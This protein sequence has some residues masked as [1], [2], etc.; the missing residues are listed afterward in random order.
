M[1][2]GATGFAETRTVHRAG[3][4][5]GTGIDG[6]DEKSPRPAPFRH[7]ADPPHPTGQG[8]A[9]NFR[10]A[11]KIQGPALPVANSTLTRSPASALYC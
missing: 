2:A 11:W 6:E 1:N 3:P 7:P 9:G 5:E 10:G 4:R 8:R